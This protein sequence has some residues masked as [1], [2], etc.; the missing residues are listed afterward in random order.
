M[1]QKDERF[2]SVRAKIL[3]SLV[4]VSV[5]LM[6]AVV[7]ITYALSVSR[8]EKIGMQLSAQYVVSAG[9]EFTAADPLS[10]A[11][12]RKRAARLEPMHSLFV[13]G[14]G[15]RVEGGMEVPVKPQ[16]G[17]I[18]DSAIPI[19]GP[20]RVS[21]L[22]GGPDLPPPCTLESLAGWETFSEFFSG[23]MLYRTTFDLGEKRPRRLS[24]GHVRE[25]AHVRLNGRDLGVRFMPPYDYAVPADIL[26][27]T[28]NELEVEVTN[29][30]ANRIRWN[31]VNKVVWKYFADINIVDAK[32]KKFDASSWKPLPSGLFGPVQMEVQGE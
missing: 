3:W 19:K 30:G 4:F 24:L 18:G 2:V 14:D 9:E 26:M 31:D 10:G 16:K 32:Y 21:A 27:E 12:A 11:I 25:I 5:P 23:T 13:V 8:V 20:W 29:L 28:G 17:G 6:I 1:K 22:S 15:F 7:L